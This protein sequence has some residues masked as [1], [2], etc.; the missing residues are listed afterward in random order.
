V[1]WCG[2]GLVLVAYHEPGLDGHHGIHDHVR[3]HAGR[4]SGQHLLPKYLLMTL[5]SILCHLPTKILNPSFS[6]TNAKSSNSLKQSTPVSS[7]LPHQHFL[8]PPPTLFR[9][10]I[11]RSFNRYLRLASPRLAS[12]SATNL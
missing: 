3:Q 5:I 7:P 11:E 1:I 4:S 10:K 9:K 6:T 8:N 2:F 12:I